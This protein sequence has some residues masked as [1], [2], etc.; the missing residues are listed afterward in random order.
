MYITYEVVISSYS[1]F[2]FFQAEDG[3]RDI[4]VTGVQTCALPIC[5][6]SSPYGYCRQLQY[7]IFNF[8]KSLKTGKKRQRCLCQKADGFSWRGFY[9]IAF[10]GKI[11]LIAFAGFHLTSWRPCWCTLNKRILII[12]FCL[13]HLHG[14]YVYCLLCL[15]KQKRYKIKKKLIKYCI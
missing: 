4:G 13:G 14:G 9:K 10:D 7:P 3:I 11:L 6:G 2:F 1:V 12:F 8:A 5:R 15:F